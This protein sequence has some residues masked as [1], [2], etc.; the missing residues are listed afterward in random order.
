[1]QVRLEMDGAGWMRLLLTH[2]PQSIQL[3]ASYLHDTPREL[4]EA[5]TRLLSHTPQ[6][7]RVAF[8]F[9]PDEWL[10]RLRPLAGGLLRIEV[11]GPGDDGP[12][13]EPFGEPRFRHTEPADRFAARVFGEFQRVL[14]EGGEADYVH[15]WGLPFPRRAYDALASVLRDRP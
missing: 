1:M 14:G 7:E 8:L 12:P 2:G 4:L 15:R 3:A 13:P 10:L 5:L 6:E 11:H 9:E